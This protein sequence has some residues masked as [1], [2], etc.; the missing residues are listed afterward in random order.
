MRPAATHLTALDREDRFEP[1]RMRWD[2]NLGGQANPKERPGSRLGRL[3]AMNRLTSLTTAHK[4]ERRRTG[5]AELA[6][7]CI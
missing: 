6:F 3:L 4:A 5:G 7:F 2:P 1:R